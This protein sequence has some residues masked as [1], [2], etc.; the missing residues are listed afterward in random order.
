MLIPTPIPS[1]GSP[2]LKNS[3]GALLLAAT[4]GSLFLA[5]MGAYRGAAKPLSATG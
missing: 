3:D 5:F 1:A 2:N 4:A